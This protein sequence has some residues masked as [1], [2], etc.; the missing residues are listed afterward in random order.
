MPARSSSAA[1][2]S[3]SWLS[4]KA[5]L[6]AIARDAA[7]SVD[8]GAP[9]PRRHLVRRITAEA[10]KAQPG[11]VPYHILEI[12]DGFG[13]GAVAAIFDLGEIAPHCDVAGIGWIDRRGRTHAAARVARKPVG[14]ARH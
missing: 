7:G 1:S 5:M 9:H 10:A 2:R 12:R 13:L 8:Q 14:M 6:D 3:V 4:G 11:I